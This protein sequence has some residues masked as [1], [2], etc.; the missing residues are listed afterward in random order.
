MLSP[1]L[2]QIRRLALRRKPLEDR[3]SRLF[4]VTLD[5][6]HVVQSSFVEVSI[7]IY[8]TYICLELVLYSFKCR[9]ARF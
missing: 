3:Q 9:F 1:E 4:R 8:K 7:D 2:K 6:L 5:D